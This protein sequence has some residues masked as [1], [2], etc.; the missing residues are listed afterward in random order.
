MS[1]HPGV[2]LAS[3]SQ[4][5]LDEAV[6][7]FFQRTRQEQEL[8]LR[9]FLIAPSLGVAGRSHSSRRSRSPGIQPIPPPPVTLPASLF[10][11]PS[12]PS[13]TPALL[14]DVP[15]S[16][17]PSP[18]S[19]QGDS[20]S[21]PVSL[22]LPS[23]PYDTPS[24]PIFSPNP[25]FSLNPSSST[26]GLNSKDNHHNNN[27]VN[28]SRAAPP[29]WHNN[30]SRRLDYD[31]LE[32]TP[33]V[34]ALLADETEL[35]LFSLVLKKMHS[36]ENLSFLL[37]AIP[38][39]QEMMKIHA[40]V[41]FRLKGLVEK[42]LSSGSDD[43]LNIDEVIR[44]RFFEQLS[45]NAADPL[46]LDEAIEC[47]AR[48]ME[49]DSLR[50]Y[51]TTLVEQRAKLAH[52]RDSLGTLGPSYRAFLDVLQTK[53]PHY[54]SAVELLSAIATARET[55]PEDPRYKHVMKSLVFK[56]ICVSEVPIN[57]DMVA[58]MTSHPLSDI[59]PGH[60]EA[61]ELELLAFVYAR[62]KPLL[63][64]FEIP[65]GEQAGASPKDGSKQISGRGRFRG[66]RSKEDPAAASNET[67]LQPRTTH[68]LKLQRSIVSEFIKP[69]KSPSLSASSSSTP[70]APPG[71]GVS[72]SL[73][74]SESKRNASASP[75]EGSKR[76]R[77]LKKKA[78]T[79]AQKEPVE[80]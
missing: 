43:R 72:G 16:P 74:S 67:K 37:E 49:Q 12:S 58:F 71:G 21:I 33:K 32:A 65:S 57:Q 36:A 48:L 22:P 40:D 5:S 41:G 53:N 47:I 75:G 35:F 14:L 9:E 30:L 34:K 55:S 66:K 25:I 26:P 20:S 15:S 10:P 68:E 27:N 51:E 64:S 39:R 24:P 77:W 79:M 44:L 69:P 31:P 19:C 11:E 62:V 59:T 28:M 23:S 70:A 13:P 56:K 6:S 17:A 45:F 8:L 42:F 61:V 76:K 3:L 46:I 7:S 29:L 63:A 1:Q 80:P 52:F 50:R 78:Q 60:L 38:Y 2:T 4:L 73:A 54:A 18:P